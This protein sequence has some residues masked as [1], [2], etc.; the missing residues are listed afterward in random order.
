LHDHLRAELGTVLELPTSD[1]N[2]PTFGTSIEHPEDP[3][4]RGETAEPHEPSFPPGP[5]SFL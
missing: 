1:E 4:D 5:S 3:D 2:E